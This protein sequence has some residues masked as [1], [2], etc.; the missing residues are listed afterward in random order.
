[1]AK[2]FKG[3]FGKPR[4]KK[5]AGGRR[6]S[7]RDYCFNCFSA[8]QR[9]MQVVHNNPDLKPRT[10]LNYHTQWKKE[11]ELTRDSGNRSV[12][13][14]LHRDFHDPFIGPKLVKVL[15]KRYHVP[16]EELDFL[17]R[18]PWGIQ[19]VL[20]GRTKRQLMI[21]SKLKRL[22]KALEFV[23]YCDAND[24]PI[25]IVLDQACQLAYKVQDL[26][27]AE[28]K[29]DYLEM[30]DAERKAHDKYQS[31]EGVDLM[32]QEG[33]AVLD[34]LDAIEQEKKRQKRSG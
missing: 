15:A 26:K 3:L 9:P 19:G 12:Y 18:R 33:Q 13:N 34:I 20:S 30:D 24:L 10:V 27:D 28:D 4:K 22:S 23:S 14:R 5:R 7:I 29:V 32:K 1:M 2:W 31:K 8:G 11:D 21:Q 25:D 16:P 17:V 6:D